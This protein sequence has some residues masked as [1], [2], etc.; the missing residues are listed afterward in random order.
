MWD[1]TAIILKYLWFIVIPLGLI[2][3]IL[4]KIRKAS[5]LTEKGVSSAEADAAYRVIA[6]AIVLTAGGIG[7]AQLAGGI[8]NPFF[9]YSGNLHNHYVVAGKVVL[10]LFWL[11][12]LVWAW[13]SRQF[14]T[15]A[16]LILPRKARVLLPLAKPFASL[17]AAV[18]LSFLAFYQGNRVPFAILNLS[19]HAI[20]RIAIIHQ[21]NRYPIDGIPQQT[22][23]VR[24]I[25]LN[26][27]S[28]FKIQY[29]LKDSDKTWQAVIPFTISEFS[30]GFV[31]LIFSRD[32]KLRVMDHRLLR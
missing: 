16:R 3:L 7:L 15:Y 27:S 6:A 8:A 31:Q 21:N 32:G 4:F 5:V 2:G 10:G 26:G 22:P 11:G 17:V 28:A 12:L 18:G 24:S 9:L 20:E 13:G 30:M 25:P 19:N 1:T 29:K 23:I 14:M